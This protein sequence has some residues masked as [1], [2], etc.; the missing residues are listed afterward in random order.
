M[1][2]RNLVLLGIIL[3][4]V[5]VAGAGYIFGNSDRS[6]FL[7][8]GTVT[9]NQKEEVDSAEITGLKLD[10]GSMDIE[11]VKGSNPDRII[12]S[13]TGRASKKFSDDIQL[14]LTRSDGVVTFKGIEDS[15]FSFGINIL[16]V[17]LKIELPQRQF[18]SISVDIGSGDIEMDSTQ[19]SDLKI[20]IGSGD[21]ELSRI[22]TEQANIESGSGSIEIDNSRT[23]DL[24]A[25]LSSGNIELSQVEGSM[26]LET[27]S[28]NIKAELQELTQP[29]SAST[30]S[31]N[32]SVLTDKAP[33]S[34]T[35]QYSILSGNFRNDWSGKEETDGG[36]Q[37]IK[38]GAGEVPV[39]LS[40]ASGNI[41]L[42]SK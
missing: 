16:E 41:S 32:I 12:A 21:I 22:I 18:D 25:Q 31:G 3:L 37:T 14:K 40:T 30:L 20:Q 38:F 10:S 13:L 34:A 35:V 17:S 1:G 19:T 11:I 24:K 33:T 27:A 9:I 6:E 42:K 7:N 23:G 26:A 8:F 2:M 5:G 29:F 15:G 4:V 28:G 39:N 36:E